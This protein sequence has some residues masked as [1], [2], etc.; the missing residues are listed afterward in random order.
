MYKNLIRFLKMLLFQDKYAIISYLSLTLG[1]PENAMELPGAKALGY[2]SHLSRLP[3]DH[4][5]VALP[6]NAAEYENASL[7]A[8][9]FPTIAPKAGPIEFAYKYI[10]YC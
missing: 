6:D 2:F 5:S 8:I 1:M 7:E 10:Q 9:L 3:V 4:L